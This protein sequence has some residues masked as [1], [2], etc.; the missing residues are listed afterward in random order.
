M[1]HSW[2]MTIDF[3]IS[4]IQKRSIMMGYFLST[5][6]VSLL[7]TFAVVI[8][9]ECYIVFLSGGVLLSVKQ[10]GML[11]VSCLFTIFCS[12]AFMFFVASFFRRIDTFSTMTS[13]IGPLLGFLTGCYVPIGSLPET[14]QLVVTYFPLT[15]GVVLIRKVLTENVFTSDNEQMVA[16]V[17]EELG[18]T[19]GVQYETLVPLAIL[20]LSGVVFLAIALWNIK[21]YEFKR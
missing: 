11:G 10:W 19:M 14:A 6:L 5:F 13:T 3:M 12:S 7:I 15:S 21:R 9:A 2:I 1:D 4:P 18:I 8:V 16:T 17:K 20:A